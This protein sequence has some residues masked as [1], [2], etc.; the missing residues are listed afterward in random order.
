MKVAFG[1][2]NLI[3]RFFPLHCSSVER[4]VALNENILH[5]PACDCSS[6]S[7]V[8]HVRLLAEL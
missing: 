4:S 2:H 8:M 3:K 5:I 6:L 7:N 1:M